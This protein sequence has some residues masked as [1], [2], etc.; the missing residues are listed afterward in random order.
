MSSQSIIFLR[1]S[2][3]T[4]I[5]TAAMQYSYAEN[6]TSFESAL[7]K[8]QSYQTQ[9]KLWQQG[10]QISE[11][12]I[13]QSRLWQNPSISLEKSGFGSDQ[14]QEFSIGISQPLDLFGERKLKQRMAQTSNQ[15]IQ[16]QQQLWKAQS[17]LIVKFAWSQL[18]LAQVEQSV[19]ASQLTISKANLDSAQKRYQAGSIALV[20][21]ERAQ[22]EALDVKRLYQQALLNQQ[23][24]ERQLSNLW[25]ETAA[26]IQPNKKVVPWPEHSEQVVQRYIA[27]GWLEKL[28][29]LNIQQ[30]DHQI[31]NLRIQA[32]PHPTLNVDMKRS[33]TPNESNDTTLAIGVAV[34]LNIFNRQ[35]YAIPVVQQQ[36]ILLNQQQQRELKQQILD[37]ANS[38]HQLKG[39][40]NQ[41][42]ATT[43]Q[44]T[45]ATKV[46]SRILQGFQAGKLS[47]NDVQQATTQLQN[48]RLGQLQ[49]LR[50]A[51]QTA[52][53]AEA[54]SIGTSYEEI[55]RSDAY[56]QLNKKAVEAS[57]NLINGGAR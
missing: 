49:I 30:S 26:A 47:I 11:L 35:Q 51:W 32:R 8:V 44:L 33:K 48:L 45:L 54:L 19:Y 17:Q 29:I 52:L 4:C 28:Y 7:A 18:L 27:E 20:D 16:L 42:D 31:E 40:R 56:T 41:F 15:Q 34:P 55:S 25:G 1:Y 38:M 10:Q 43:A 36:Q 57:Q 5:C 24:A 6:V 37:I 3:V 21:F 9:D 53:A 12:N 13:Q 39:L 23:V 46:Q 14:E 50:Q 2:L 22:I